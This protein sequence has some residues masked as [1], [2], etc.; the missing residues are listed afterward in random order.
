MRRAWVGG[1][2]AP[3][4]CSAMNTTSA[5]MEIP[6]TTFTTASG[7]LT[8][9]TAP[10]ADVTTVMAPSG[11]SSGQRSTPARA[12]RAVADMVMNVTANM[13]VATAW[14]GDIPTVI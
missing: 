1:G 5:A 13:L 10:S 4:R 7:S 3:L 9:M 14:R 6:T 2:G 11:T 8:A 12:K